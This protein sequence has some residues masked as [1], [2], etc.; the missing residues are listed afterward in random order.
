MVV[1][2]P[3]V[4][5]G[6]PLSPWRFPVL[7]SVRGWVDHSA[8]G[9]IRSFEK[10]NDFVGNR[11]CDFPACSIVL[12][13]TM[14]LHQIL[15]SM[16]WWCEWCASQCQAMFASGMTL[17]D[18]VFELPN[19]YL[20]QGYIGYVFSY[21]NSV[22]IAKQ[23]HEPSTGV[24]RTIGQKGVYYVTSEIIKIHWRKVKWCF[25][26][27]G[28]S[29]FLMEVQKLIT[30]VSV[31]QFAELVEV[32]D[33]FGRKHIVACISYFRRGFGLVNWFI[34]YSQ[35]V[36]STISCNTLTLTVTITH[37]NYEQW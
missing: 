21:Y 15:Q 28:R 2:L 26:G 6:C 22:H 25:G 19:P 16:E 13:P 14:L 11:T 27:T 30:V 35:Q 4:H 34:G 20:Q 18:A 3:A 1:R 24:V 29:S 10:S 5:T 8:A 7:I 12:Q 37:C 17:W 33:K 23:L 32:S 36:V 31:V 9:R